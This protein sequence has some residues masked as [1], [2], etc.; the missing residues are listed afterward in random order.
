LTAYICARESYDALLDVEKM[1]V[2]VRDVDDV[3]KGASFRDEESKL[4]FAYDYDNK[5]TCG[6]RQLRLNPRYI[7][8]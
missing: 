4:L 3:F 6:F 2:K 8:N 5:F 7:T 1:G